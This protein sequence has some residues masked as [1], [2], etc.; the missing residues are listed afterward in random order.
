VPPTRKSSAEAGAGRKAVAIAAAAK[1]QVS[2]LQ[3]AMD[4]VLGLL[5]V[6]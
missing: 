2:L 6:I 4:M 3:K 1:S 5:L